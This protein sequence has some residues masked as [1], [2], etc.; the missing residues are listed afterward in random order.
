MKFL[1]TMLRVKDLDRALD[2]FVTKLGLIEIKRN[3]YPAGKFSLVFLATAKGEPEI[4][5]THNWGTEQVSE[6]EYTHGRNFGH[7]AFQVDNIYETCEQLMSKGVV[8]HRPPRDGYMAFIK[9]PDNQSV[10]LLQKGDPLPPKSPWKE[11]E[12]TGTW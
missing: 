3:D 1:H 9:S 5:L 12:N 7:L 11:M 6:P 10:E 4:E 8:I 2:F